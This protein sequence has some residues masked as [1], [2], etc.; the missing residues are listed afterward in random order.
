MVVHPL[1]GTILAGLAATDGCIRAAAGR[2][3]AYRSSFALTV[4]FLAALAW[5]DYELNEAMA[6]SGVPGAAVIAAAALA[7]RIASYVRP[8]AR[9]ARL[10]RCGSAAARVLTSRRTLG[11]LALAGLLVV[12]DLALWE[13]MLILNP[14]HD[15]LIHSNRLALYWGEDRWRW[16]LMYAAGATGIGGLVRL[17]ARGRPLP[18]LWFS[19]YLG[20][21]LAGAAGLPVPV[22]WRFLL[23]AQVPL[24]IG[25]GVVL[26]E[27][28]TPSLQHVVRGT[29]VFALAFKLVTLFALP[30][31]VTYFGNELQPAYALGRIIPSAPAG[32]VASD[33]FTSYYIPGDTGRG[34]LTM[35]KA[36]VGSQAE[37]TRRAAATTCCTAS[38]SRPTRTGGRAARRCGAPT[39]ASC[40]WRSAHRSPPRTSRCSRPDRRRSCA[41]PRTRAC[42]AGCSGGS[43]ASARCSIPTASTRC[44][45]SIERRCS[46]RSE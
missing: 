40:S 35:T 25:V 18:L 28:P 31:N 4:G 14:P 44:T 12:W 30:A 22:W 11:W 29:L 26:V 33:P 21:A 15:P 46:R 17:A 7:P 27:V 42:S 41:H 1:T 23:L 34:V 24:A 32:L 20:I 39:C 16:F 38:T 3:G 37:L 43:G 2:P 19:G 13:V 5:P 45:A 10:R 9:G 36:H 8:L 6:Q